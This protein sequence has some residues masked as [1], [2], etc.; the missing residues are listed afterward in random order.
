M[1][2]LLKDQTVPETGVLTLTLDQ[3]VPINVSATEAQRRVSRFVHWEISSQMHGKAP[4]LVIGDRAG[5]QVPVHLTFPSFG[6]V[7]CVGEIVVDA[8]TGQ[9][10]TDPL[11]IAE[12]ERRAQELATRFTSPAKNRS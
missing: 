3:T 10:Q 7:G 1:N 5:W 11:L 4:T 9:L 12:I 8:E 6:D 2:V